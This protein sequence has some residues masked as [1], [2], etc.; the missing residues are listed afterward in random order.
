MLGMSQAASSPTAAAGYGSCWRKVSVPTPTRMQACSLHNL[1]CRGPN[2]TS[3]TKSRRCIPILERVT[4]AIILCVCSDTAALTAVEFEPTPLRNGALS[5]RLRPL[6]QTVMLWG[7]GMS[8]IGNKYMDIGVR[9]YLYTYRCA[10]THVRINLNICVCARR[11]VSLLL[12]LAHSPLS[13][14]P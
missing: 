14:S 12:S 8:Q 3:E 13:L 11:C 1:D 2:P 4:R 10:Y 5:H 9:I 7:V 6:G